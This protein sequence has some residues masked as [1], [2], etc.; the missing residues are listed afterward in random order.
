MWPELC[1]LTYAVFYAM[2]TGDHKARAW[3]GLS[4]SMME[5]ALIRLEIDWSTEGWDRQEYVEWFQQWV[6]QMNKPS[7]A[8]E[9]DDDDD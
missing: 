2:K 6:E 8:Q 7:N 4:T 1:Q 3:Q 5:A 9:L